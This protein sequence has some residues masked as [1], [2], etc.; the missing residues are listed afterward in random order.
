GTISRVRF[1]PDSLPQ[2]SNAISLLQKILELGK[3]DELRYVKTTTDRYNVAHQYYVQ[4]YKG[5]PVSFAMYAVHGKH[6]KISVVN[7]DFARIGNINVNARLS[8]REA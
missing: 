3:N 2:F 6:N 1:K 4:Y 8:E 7:G 5:C